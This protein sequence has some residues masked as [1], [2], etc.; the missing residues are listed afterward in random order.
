MKKTSILCAAF[1]TLA[2]TGAMAPAQAAIINYNVTTTWYEPQTQPRNSIFQGSFTYDTDTLTVSDLQGQLSESM[3]D[4]NGMPIDAGHMVWLNLN[5]QLVAWYDDTL[6]GTFA[7]AFRNPTTATFCSSVMCGSPADNWSPATG[8]AVGGIYSGFPV[9]GNN[10]GNAYAL[11]FVPDNPTDALTQAQI[12]KLAYADCVPTAP[13]GMMMGG[14]MMGAVCMTGTSL[15]GYGAAGTMD[16]Y[17]I[18]QSISTVPLPGALPLLL[19]G[20]GLLGAG[21]RRKA[22]RVA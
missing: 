3:T 14:G 10:P 20:L 2:A 9:A 22:A 11:I 7:A 8:V 5:Y 17:P 12:D 15:A 13:G 21:A 16:G 18:S 1:A 19:S 6:G 4:T